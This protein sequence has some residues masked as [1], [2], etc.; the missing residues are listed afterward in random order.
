MSS[1]RQERDEFVRRSGPIGPERRTA[2]T[3]LTDD[4]IARLFEHAVGNEP[5]FS[6]IAVGGHGRS[7][8]APGSDLDLVLLHRSDPEKARLV[9]E[10]LWYPIWD[11]GI[12][13]DHSVR[14]FGEARQMASRDLKVMLGLM[15]ARRVAGDEPMATELVSSVLADWR[16]TA[17]KRLPELRE[18]VQARRNQFG[19]VST[20]LEPDLKESYGGLREGTVLRAI[21]ASWVTDVPHE[22]WSGELAFLL[23]VRYALHVVTGRRS[24]QLVLQE[25]SSVAE[26]LGLTDSNEL[27]RRVYAAARTIAYASDVAWYRVS[28]LEKTTTNIVRRAFIRRGQDRVPLTD[29]AVVQSGEVVLAHDVEPSSDPVL[30]LRVAAAAAQSGLPVAPHTVDRLAA[31]SGPMPRPW[32]RSAR[33]AFISLL[34]AGRP[35]LDIWEAFDQA[36]MIERLLPGW[37]VVRSAPQRDPIHRFTVDRHLVEAAI[38]A[39]GLTR[40]VDRPDLLLVAALLHDIGKARGGRHADVGAEIAEGLAAWMGFETD[41]VATIAFLVRWHLLLADVAT[42]R[43]LD[44]PATLRDV[45]QHVSTQ[46]RLDLLLALTEADS[47]A[48]SPAMWNDWRRRLVEE[49][50]WRCTAALAGR[51]QPDPFQLSEDQRLLLGTSGVWALIDNE[52]DDVKVTVG[53]PDRMGLLALVAGLLSMHRLQVRAARVFTVEDRAV[54]EWTVRPLYG[55]PPSVEVFVE[56]LRRA[57]DGAI[58]VGAKLAGR[59]AAYVR[60]GATYPPAVV[61]VVADA[62][63]RATVLEVR[64]HDAPAL[65]YRVAS[66]VSAAGASIQGAKVSTLGSEVIDVFFLTDRVGQPLSRDHA[67]AVRVTVEATLAESATV[68]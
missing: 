47:R 32:P 46:E 15:D 52:P 30:W 65:L 41:D 26:L 20:L 45:L 10:K 28:R 44:D 3:A 38:E 63:R 50:A 55:D 16:A 7:E 35:T 13:L 19:D 6:L 31:E 62:D 37:E 17:T 60:P 54:Q 18:M 23:D 24:D 59:E 68:R 21:A 9:A 53:A 58:D 22:R 36:G 2:L 43:D 29:G 5:G 64:A 27:L 12:S 1:I 51:P 14:S 67:D 66:A 39:S 34:G 25:Q 4:W 42:R 40:R 8:L 48:T 57:L 33:E 49:L 56:E 61:T 11:S